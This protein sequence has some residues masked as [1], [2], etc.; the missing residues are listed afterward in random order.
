[1]GRLLPPYD[2]T[3]SSTYEGHHFCEAAVLLPSNSSAECI[4]DK[5]ILKRQDPILHSCQLDLYEDEM[6][7]NGSTIC[8]VRFVS[9]SLFD[10]TRFLYDFT[11]IYFC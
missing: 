11:L 10:L 4:F 3:F 1:M 9:V 6:G 5:S 8:D 7:D 2:W